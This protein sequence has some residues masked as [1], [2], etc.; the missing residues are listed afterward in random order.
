[1]PRLAKRF[2]KAGRTGDPTMKANATPRPGPTHSLPRG[3]RVRFAVSTALLCGL[4][5]TSFAL[6]QVERCGDPLNNRN[7]GPFDY[8][9]AR[10]EDLKIVQDVHFTSRIEQLQLGERVLGDDIGYTLYVFPN[11]HRALLAMTRLAERDKTD[12]PQK[13]THTIDCWYDRAVRF[14]PDDTVV[15]VLYAQYLGKQR[16]TE[17][18]M[19]QL[20]LAVHHAQDNPFSHFN[21]GLLYF[22]LG[23][24]ELA[25]QQAH[26]AM[27]LGMQRTDLVDQLKR[28]GKWREPNQ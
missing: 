12:K 16:R 2:S 17:E 20:G 19:Q 28:A 1:M 5:H 23:N 13:S 9:S 26:K 8:R 14:K 6:A 4:L 7:F 27:S 15:R 24:H 25:L 3:K 11:H 10:K 21:I 22:E 18:A